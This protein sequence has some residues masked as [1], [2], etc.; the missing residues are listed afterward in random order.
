MSDVELPHGIEI[1]DVVEF[2]VVGGDKRKKEYQVVLDIN[3]ST[4]TITKLRGLMGGREGRL[5]TNYDRNPIVYY[6]YKDE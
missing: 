3:A 2:N 1:D 6:P 5:N 4:K